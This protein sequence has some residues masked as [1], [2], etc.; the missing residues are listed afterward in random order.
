MNYY[1]LNELNCERQT[2]FMLNVNSVMMMS[3]MRMMNMCMMMRA[4][5]RLFAL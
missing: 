5:N 3:S 1:H 4:R 2:G